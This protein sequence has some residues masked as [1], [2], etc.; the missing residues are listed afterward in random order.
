ML[1]FKLPEVAAALTEQEVML[2]QAQQ[3]MAALVFKARLMLLLMAALAPEDRRVPVILVEVVEAE[4]VQTQA[5][6]TQQAQAALV[7]EAQV[8]PQEQVVQEQRILEVVAVV[9]PAAVQRM[10]E[11]VAQASSSSK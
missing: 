7:V 6:Q 8:L 9:V 11:Q 2:R 3:E 5:L 10:A 1:M 4:S